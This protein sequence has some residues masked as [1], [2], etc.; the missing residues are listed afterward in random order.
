MEYVTVRQ[1]RKI[2]D[3]KAAAGVGLWGTYDAAYMIFFDFFGD[4]DKKGRLRLSVTGKTWYESV[5]Y[6]V[7]DSFGAEIKVR[8][9]DDL[10]RLMAGVVEGK[11]NKEGWETFW[12]AVSAAAVDDV[13]KN[14]PVLSER[15][16]LLSVKARQAK[17]VAGID[18]QLSVM[19]GWE[20]GN[21]AQRAR[22]ADLI[23]RRAVMV[24]DWPI[25]DA[26]IAE[27]DA[28]LALLN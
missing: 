16:E 12:G 13:R 3:D 18:G 25:I 4:A 28:Q 11:K 26:R 17:R 14:K 20:T 8:S 5:E 10:L 9:I 23:Q 1:L 19:T 21:A 7:V 24:A 2:V 15:K 22:K 27:I 6:V